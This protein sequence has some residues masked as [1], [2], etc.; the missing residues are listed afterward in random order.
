[1]WISEV[2]NTSCIYLSD[3][4]LIYKKLR[5]KFIANLKISEILKLQVSRNS[6]IYARTR[7]CIYCTLSMEFSSV[8]ER[9]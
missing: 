6:V 8:N 1:M 9:C 7:V 3:I 5:I 2:G 4:R